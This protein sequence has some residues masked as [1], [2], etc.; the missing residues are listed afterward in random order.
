[1]YNNFSGKRDVYLDIAE[2]YIQYIKLGVIKQGEKLPSVR[3]AAGELGVNPNTVAKAYS[4]LEEKGYI[5]SIPKKGA[6]V[7][8]GASAK[9]DTEAQAREWLS[10]LRE[11]GVSKQTLEKIIEEVYLENDRD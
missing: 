2:R 11:F 4:T 6:F 8:H 3:E 7:T 5:R 1:M 9:N 10:A